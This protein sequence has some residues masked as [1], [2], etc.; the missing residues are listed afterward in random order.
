[1]QMKSGFILGN[2]EFTKNDAKWVYTTSS[3]KMTAVAQAF[4]S[5][6]TYMTPS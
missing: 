3:A 6:P 2:R 5:A 4:F 1:M